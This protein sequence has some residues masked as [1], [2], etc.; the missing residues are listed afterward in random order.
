MRR[1]LPTSEFSIIENLITSIPKKLFQKMLFIFLMNIIGYASFGQGQFGGKVS[2]LDNS[3]I[4]TWYNTNSQTCDGAGTGNLSSGNITMATPTY[5]GDKLYIGGNVL[6]F[7][8]GA[9]GDIG[10]LRWQ[11]YPVGGTAPGYNAYFTLP[12]NNRSYAS[13]IC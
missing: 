11:F 10:Q 9:S 8:F 1:V 3:G 2:I 12:F 6:T 13:L 4:T 5:L 7:G